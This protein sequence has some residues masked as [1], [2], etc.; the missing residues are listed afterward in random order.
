MLQGYLLNWQTQKTIWDATF[1]DHLKFNPSDTNFIVTEPVLNFTAIKDPWDEAIFEEYGFKSL[2]RCSGA[3]LTAFQYKDTHPE[4]QCCLVID[5][6]HAFTHIVPY[7]N[8]VQIPAGIR[9]I[10]LGGIV[11]S[12]VFYCSHY[13]LALSMERFT[14]PEILFHP[15]DIGVDE[16][17]LGE[18][19]RESVEACP[20]AMQPHLYNNIVII[21]G[22]SKFQNFKERVYKEVRALAPDEFPVTV[23]RPED[24]IVEAWK[25]GQLL[26]N[27]P[28]F[29]DLRITKQEYEE[30]GLSICE[31]KLTDS[32][33]IT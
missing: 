22:N 6:G 10:N 9:R 15:S 23:H 32:I 17:G 21:G 13:Q 12:L 14:V 3:T 11:N 2:F 25:G 28:H 31:E 24:P 18:A 5:S 19:I 4:S 16:M 29:T 33:H 7:H 26:A 27:W 8:G 20:P 30:Y 1:N